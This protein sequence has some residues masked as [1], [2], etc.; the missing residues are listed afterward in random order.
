[1]SPSRNPSET[2]F[3]VAQRVGPRAEGVWDV[4]GESLVRYE[5]HLTGRQVEMRRG[6]IEL[7]G[8]GIRLIRPRTGGVGVGFASS[9]DL[10]D[11][12]I[13]RAIDDARA[14]GS[15]GLF[16]AAS[17]ELPSSSASAVAVE[18]VD[19]ELWARP[20][21]RLE[22]FV[23]GLLEPFGSGT[24]PSASFGSVRA[25]LA[26]A[27]IANSSGIER[28]YVRSQVDLEF[29]VKSSDGPEG[30]APGEYWVN[31]TGCRLEGLA[32]PAM[33]ESWRRK[34]TEVRSASPTPGGD[35]AVVLP[36]EVLSD[37]VPPILGFRLGG[38]AALRGMMPAPGT[39]IA[40]ASMEIWDDGLFPFG[41]STA[42]W[43]DEGAP[44]GRRHLV[45]AGAFREGFF[46][47]LHA[48]AV[49]RPATASA[50]RDPPSSAPW[51]RF[52]QAP[53]PGPT[54]L[55]IPSGTGGS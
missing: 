54:T 50:R 30:P 37:I 19:R 27:T 41:P 42:P 45:E 39:P 49:G 9:T 10:S 17:V 5:V 12:G 7:E 33:A 36:P 32:S 34:A 24:G 29:A 20:E 3:R 44:Q 40:V 13:D 18:S 6:P 46:D 22:R 26:E 14:A 35:A 43:D 52:P 47:S 4:F 55:V 21:E 11:R 15:Q 28:R 51:F 23:E 25:T 31:R 16:P 2:A 8:Y 48:G 38:S 1:M 53:S